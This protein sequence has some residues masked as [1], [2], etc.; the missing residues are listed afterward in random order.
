MTGF[1]SRQVFDERV[2][3]CV[4]IYSVF[5]VGLGKEAK[6]KYYIQDLLYK[7]ALMLCI[8]GYQIF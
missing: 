3:L 4:F 1:G 2:Y 8:K 7:H 6:R 5:R